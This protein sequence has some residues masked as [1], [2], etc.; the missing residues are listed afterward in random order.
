MTERYHTRQQ[1]A[2]DLGISARTL[3]RKIKLLSISMPRGLIAPKLYQQ[4]LEK[5]RT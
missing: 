2:A 4:L 3:S 5:L 1:L